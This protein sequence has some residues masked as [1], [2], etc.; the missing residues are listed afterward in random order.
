[1]PKNINVRYE[2]AGDI[3][4]IHGDKSQLGQLIINIVTNAVEAIGNQPGDIVVSCEQVEPDAQLLAREATPQPLP[5][6]SYVALRITDNGPGIPEEIR[7]RMFDPFITTRET[8]RGMGLPAVLGIVRGHHGAII[9][10]SSAENGTAMT[11]LLPA[12]PTGDPTAEI[13]TEEP[14]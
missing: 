13:K 9:V 1:V 5:T 2:T 12:L 11:V 8:G 3:P 14:A 4:R 7:Q 10:D 6:G